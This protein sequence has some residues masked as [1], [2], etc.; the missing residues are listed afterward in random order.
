MANDYTARYV[1]Y[2]RAHGKTP[3]EMTAHDRA[4]WPG[5]LMCGFILWTRER[6]DEFHDMRGYEPRALCAADHRSF[7]AWLALRCPA[8]SSVN[9]HEASGCER[10]TPAGEAYTVKVRECADCYHATVDEQA[11]EQSLEDKLRGSMAAAMRDLNE[12]ERAAS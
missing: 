12:S 9:T 7:D 2:S 4:Q 8:C 11:A 5:G 10:L 3:A 1:A 6:W